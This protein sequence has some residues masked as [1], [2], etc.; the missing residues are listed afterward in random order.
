MIPSHYGLHILA[1]VVEVL[2]HSQLEVINVLVVQGHPRPPVRLLHHWAY[3]ESVSTE[4]MVEGSGTTLGEPS[5]E[6]RRETLES[7]CCTPMDC[8]YQYLSVEVIS[9]FSRPIRSGQRIDSSL[10][11]LSQRGKRRFPTGTSVIG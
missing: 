9:Q 6:E 8:R 11:E 4:S 1:V 5:E 7:Q 3:D 2:D 10:L